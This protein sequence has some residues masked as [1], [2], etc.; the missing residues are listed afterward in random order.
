[1]KNFEKFCQDNG[2]DTSKAFNMIVGNG[3]SV[4]PGRGFTGYFCE[5]T[6][7]SIICTN[8]KLEVKKEIPFSSFKEAE[9]GI[10]NGTLWLQCIVGNSQF[11]FNLSRNGWKSPAGKLLMDKI[12]EHTELKDMKAY[13]QYTGK[14][15]LIYMW[16]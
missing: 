12:S 13:E 10:G 15:F 1:M 7:D 16:K 3:G 8:E 5:I 9:F 4:L 6:D 14:L 11:V 2:I